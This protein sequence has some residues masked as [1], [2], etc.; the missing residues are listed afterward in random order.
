MSA[1]RGR[2]RCLFPGPTLRLGPRVASPTLALRCAPG[3]TRKHTTH[4]HTHSLS[5]LKVPVPWLTLPSSPNSLWQT[6]VS[7]ASS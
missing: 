4:T 3:A 6:N 7:P 2:A 5:D 1:E